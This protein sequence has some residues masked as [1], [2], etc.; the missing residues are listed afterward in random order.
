[1]ESQPLAAVNTRVYVPAVV[2]FCDPKAYVCPKQIDAFWYEF[3]LG[4][5]LRVSVMMESHPLILFKIIEY[6]PELLN[7]SFAQIKLCPWQIDAL[8]DAVDGLL[9]V[10]VV[11]ADKAEQVG[12][13]LTT[14]E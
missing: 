7:V 5:T 2:R 14:T 9:I 4:S 11:T 12:L 8:I 3:E 13:L 6:T 1:M 10:T